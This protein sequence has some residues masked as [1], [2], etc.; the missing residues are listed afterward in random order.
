MESTSVW[1]CREWL[2]S[3]TAKLPV[4]ID[5]NQFFVGGWIKAKT[6]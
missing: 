6:T 5:S 2:N 3:H 1:A 4:C